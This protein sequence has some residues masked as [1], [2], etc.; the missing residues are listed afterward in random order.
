MSAEDKPTKKDSKIISDMRKIRKEKPVFD[1]WYDE[2]ITEIEETDKNYEKILTEYKQ[3]IKESKDI[4][5]KTEE[6]L[7]DDGKKK[8]STSF[9]ADNIKLWIEE[10][11]VRKGILTNEKSYSHKPH[12]A[13]LPYD[14]NT[15][16][17]KKLQER[18]DACDRQI[19]NWEI[20]IKENE[21]AIKD[22]N[23]EI[24]DLKKDNKEI[25]KKMGELQGLYDEFNELDANVKDEAIN[26]IDDIVDEVN[27]LTNGE[28]FPP[29]PFNTE[30][31]D[32]YYQDLNRLKELFEDGGLLESK[33]AMLFRLDN[34]IRTGTGDDNRFNNVIRELNRVADMVDMYKNPASQE[35][36]EKRRN[37]EFMDDYEEEISKN[38]RAIEHQ[39]RTIHD[40]EDNIKHSERMVNDFSNEK[41]RTQE[42]IDRV[43]KRD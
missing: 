5:K 31:I 2:L 25:E 27:K 32:Y 21:N 14:H 18:L 20:V 22:V 37:Y 6:T 13:S 30:K 11:L 17:P 9:N 36:M 1:K 7:K 38:H 41:D 12:L 10:A 42:H 24:D 23:N 26:M 39:E 19:K 3:L 15:N 28:G 33:D 8:K 16:D 35:I 40:F 29:N 34:V 4:L 43:T